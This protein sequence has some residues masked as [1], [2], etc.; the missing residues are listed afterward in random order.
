MVR[1]IA[2][3]SLAALGLASAVPASA[4]APVFRAVPAKTIAATGNVII[5]D[6]LWACGSDGCTT[7]AATSRPA[8]VC[9]QAVKKIGKLESFAVGTTTFDEAALATCNAKARA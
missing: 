2:L 5:G 9:A 4:Q 1:S 3:A 6:T 7:A 8:I